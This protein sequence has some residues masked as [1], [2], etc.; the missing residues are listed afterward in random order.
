M[1]RISR[2]LRDDAGVALVEY[3]LVVPLLVALLFGI[4]DFG[5]AFNYWLDETHLA[6]EAA[7][8]AA[9]NRNPSTTQTLQEWIRSQGTT[10]EL[11]D[12]TG[13]VKEKLKICITFPV[14]QVVG[15]PVKVEATARY[16]WLRVLGISALSTQI[17]GSSTMRLEAPPS[18]Y[19]AGCTA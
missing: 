7:R 5:R 16:Q 6:N 1:T 8:Y 3:A 13:S 15:D 10:K 9:V 18:N 2:A 14:G 17:K 4:L 19:S 11:R 12:G